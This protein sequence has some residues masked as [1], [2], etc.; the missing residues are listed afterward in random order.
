[1]QTF[2][3]LFHQINYGNKYKNNS[4]TN[5]LPTNF[6]VLLGASSI[7][8]DAP[9]NLSEVIK[10]PFTCSLKTLSLRDTVHVPFSY[11]VVSSSLTLCLLLLALSSLVSSVSS[12]LSASVV[13]I[14]DV[15]TDLCRFCRR[16]ELRAL[17]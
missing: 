5:S 12:P 16:G 13:S 17:R 15:S 7:I 8:V 4:G 3:L 11:A 10:M 6:R 14:K 9:N 1:M 2:S